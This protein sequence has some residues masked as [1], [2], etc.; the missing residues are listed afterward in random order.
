MFSHIL[1]GINSPSRFVP[2]L[3]TFTYPSKQHMAPQ[4]AGYWVRYVKVN[5]PKSHLGSGFEFRCSS[6]VKLPGRD[7][8]KEGI[9]FFPQNNLCI[10]LHS[11][12]ARLAELLPLVLFWV[13]QKPC[14]SA[15]GQC[16]VGAERTLALLVPLLQ[17]CINRDS[18]LEDKDR[19]TSWGCLGWWEMLGAWGF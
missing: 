1:L 19:D 10:F 5:W 13:T 8:V 12:F 14:M 11:C 4:L 6:M 2:M 9:S 18:L 3:L 16:L 7:S 15:G 17:C